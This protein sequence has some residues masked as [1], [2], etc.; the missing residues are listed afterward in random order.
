MINS[1]YDSYQILSKVYKDGAFLKQAIL[2][3]T[4]EEKNRAFVTKLVY[5]VLDKDIELQYY[6][7]KLTDKSPKLAIRVLLKI[8]MYA[9]KW[10]NKKPYVVIDNTVELVK[11]MGKKGVSG[12]VNAFLRKFCSSEIALPEKWEEQV[13][14]KY[15]FPLFYVKELVKDYGKVVAEKIMSYEN[16][17]Q[18]VCFYK[19]DGEEF[20]KQKGV[21]Y[22]KTPFE[23]VFLTK[24]FI[25]DKAYD[26]GKYTFQN[27]CSVAICDLVDK[28]CLLLD[29]CS[30]PGG[31]SIN[32]SR[33]FEK[34]V[35]TDVYAHRVELIEKYKNRMGVENL[36]TKVQDMTEYNAE[37]ENAFD[38]VL[39]DAPCTGSGVFFENPDM[40]LN[41]SEENLKN[42]VDLQQQILS[43]VKKYVKIGGYMYYSTCSLFK[44]EN[45]EQVERFLANN[46]NFELI[47][48]NS[49][50][51]AEKNGKV[52]Q[53]LP[54]ISNAGFFIAKFKRIS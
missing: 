46:D 18:T 29:C 30:A 32:L 34:V 50:W 25:R 39:V 22:E 14:I 44:K 36:F 35:S 1:F 42:L 38:A 11:K 4:I 24:N 9:I 26:E 12:F 28:G 17:L 45:V 20:L 48:L 53:F 31:K 6:L 10:L 15:S 5:G 43:N 27:I 52:V 3:T 16:V 37:F 51:F 49:K 2:N 21:V 7:D 8:S 19:G 13:S 54:H 40:K 47:D 23:E 41:K 33:K